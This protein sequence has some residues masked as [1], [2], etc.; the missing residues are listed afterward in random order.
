MVN[1]ETQLLLNHL[2]QAGGSV[3]GIDLAR[4]FHVS[5]V[6]LWKRVE[7]LRAAGY[8]IEASRSGY[9]LVPGDRPLPG[10]FPG[11]EERVFFF[12]TLG[13]T[14]DEAFRLGTSGLAEGVV[15]AE[16]QSAGRGR[17][18]RPWV[19]D[20]G[21]LL[22]TL[23]FRPDLPLS[24]VGALGLEALTALAE[25]LRD[26]CGLEARLKWPNDLVVDGRK[27]AGVLVEAVGPADRP[28]FY[29][30]GVGL[31]V[32]GRP[33]LDRPTTSLD[34][35]GHPASR[36]AILSA[37]WTRLRR[38]AA[39]PALVPSR[40]ESWSSPP[41]PWTID[42]FDGTR[43]SGPSQGFDRAGSLLVLQ[44]G[45]TIPIRYGEVRRTSGAR[46]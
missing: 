30:V 43:I 31:N 46:S 9:R 44:A 1:Q 24:M 18:D 2:R 7:A 29:S 5:R 39:E 15:V 3:S 26:V 25:T 13:S 11:D 21:D 19:S 45:K 32:H 20:G 34:A 38:W 42:T 22:A 41:T 12:E 17:A 27:L 16:R 35:E 37:W 4:R 28:R 36:Q 33:D 8:A 23:V 10:E 6:A 40:W 14:M